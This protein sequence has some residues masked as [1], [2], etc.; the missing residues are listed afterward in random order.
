[1]ARPK[2]EDV[3]FF[4]FQKFAESALIAFLDGL[5]RIIEKSK[6]EISKKDSLNQAN[7]N[8]QWRCSWKRIRNPCN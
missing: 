5:L 2:N 4:R 7:H 3:P 1:M 8:E 6:T